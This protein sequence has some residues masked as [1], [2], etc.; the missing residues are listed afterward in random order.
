MRA[1]VAAAACSVAALVGAGCGKAGTS[2]G[3]HGGDP[4]ATT[5]AAVAA[6]SPRPAPSAD[7]AAIVRVADKYVHGLGTGD[8]AAACQTRIRAE[9][10]QFARL[11]GS[12]PAAFR[13]IRR[14]PK[15][16]GFGVLAHAAARAGTVRVRGD[17]AT[18]QVFRPGQGQ[19]ALTLS[20]QHAGGRWLLFDDPATP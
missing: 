19:A 3:A 18:V 13:A 17:R 7:A 14:S 15:G 8:F 5:V 4:G 10:R 1:R 12:C 9:R 20:L 6:A 2:L 11:A 16:R